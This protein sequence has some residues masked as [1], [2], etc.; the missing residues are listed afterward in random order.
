MP[1]IG[2]MKPEQYGNW[3]D[4]ILSIPGHTFFHTSNWAAVLEETYGYTPLYL[5]QYN[6]NDFTALLPLM[7]ITSVL[8]GKRG[9]SLPFTDYCEPIGSGALQFPDMFN[10]AIAVGKKQNWKYLELR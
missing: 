8:T 10:A 9:V 7:E 5:G 1:K 2:I 6:R 4:Q 3:N